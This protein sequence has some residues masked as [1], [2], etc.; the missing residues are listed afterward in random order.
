MNCSNLVKAEKKFLLLPVIENLLN[1]VLIH[2]NKLSIANGPVRKLKNRRKQIVEQKR[3][4]NKTKKTKGE[5]TLHPS[6]YNE[7]EKPTTLSSINH[8]I[9]FFKLEKNKKKHCNPI[10]M[11]KQNLLLFSQLTEY[12]FFINFGVSIHI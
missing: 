5:E 4:K 7:Q 11:S 1:Y 8:P 10:T 2:H 9:N 3:K 12:K 6:P